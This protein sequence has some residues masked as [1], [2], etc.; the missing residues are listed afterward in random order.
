[1]TFGRRAWQT[2]EPLHGFIYFAPEAHERF[3][4]LGLHGGAGYFASRSA[5]FGR[6]SAETV[7]ATFY[8]FNPAFVRLNIPA[9]WEKATP[10]QVLAARLDAADAALRRGLGDLI[11]TDAVAETAALTR[12]AAEAA[13]QRLE[14]RPLFAA[15]AALPWPTEPH[16]ELFHAQTLLR[17]F[18]GDGHI[19]ALVTAE[20]TGLEALVVHAATGYLPAKA[21]RKTRQWSEE[22]WAAAVTVLQERKILE[23]GE[24]LAL[25]EEGRAQRQHVEDL[26]DRLAE[27]AYAALGE[28]GVERLVEVGKPLAQAVIEAGMLPHL[29]KK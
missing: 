23:P 1:M 14:G 22:D 10:E 3:E 20:L 12:K 5:A 18:R 8:N 15:H 9:A 16:L 25:T 2:I 11:G 27:P 13:C 29:K 6:A 4:A 26:T 17:E 21:L 7:I 19:A 28:D 24:E